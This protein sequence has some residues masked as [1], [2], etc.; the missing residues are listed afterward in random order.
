MVIRRQWPAALILIGIRTACGGQ[1]TGPITAPAPA[2]KVEVEDGISTVG[3]RRGN[4]P[5]CR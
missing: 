1:S 2:A 3:W 4:K 5:V